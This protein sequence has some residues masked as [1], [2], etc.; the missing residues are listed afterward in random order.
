M[1]KKEFHLLCIFPPN[2]VEIRALSFLFDCVENLHDVI[3]VFNS[4]P[5]AWPR[6]KHYSASSFSISFQLSDAIRD[7]QLGSSLPKGSS[8]A[9]QGRDW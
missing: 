1:E 4:F 8:Q 7:S 5:T 9:L 2:T 3:C 6:T